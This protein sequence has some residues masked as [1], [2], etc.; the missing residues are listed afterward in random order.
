MLK[1]EKET[2]I[3]SRFEIIEMC[4]E[5]RACETEFKKLIRSY[6]DDFYMVLLQNFGWLV[7]KGIVECP[8]SITIPNS[9]ISIGN[10]AFA[11]CTG[12]ISITIPNSVTSIGYYAFPQNCKI[13]KK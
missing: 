7:K 8:T 2:L 6:E 1:F 10:W 3:S 5:H 12:L 11:D 4:K 13:I 9:V